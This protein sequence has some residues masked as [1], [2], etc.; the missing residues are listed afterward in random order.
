M[1]S[2]KTKERNS[3]REKRRNF[4][5][6]KRWQLVCLHASLGLLSIYA[7]FNN[8]NGYPLIYDVINFHGELILICKLKQI[9]QT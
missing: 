4:S 1:T 8:K 6:N 7:I 2:S 9:K 5:N 3:K